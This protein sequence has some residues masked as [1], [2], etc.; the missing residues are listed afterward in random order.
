MA[1]LSFLPI[2]GHRACAA[3][4]DATMESTL[5]WPGTKKAENPFGS[6][7]LKHGGPTSIQSG[8]LAF[9]TNAEARNDE[10]HQKQHKQDLGNARRSSGNARKSKNAGHQG[11]QQESNGPREH[12]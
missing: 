12:G 8:I 5:H 1:P 6:S 7:A 2:S 10:Q 9:H 3:V 11:K 4:H